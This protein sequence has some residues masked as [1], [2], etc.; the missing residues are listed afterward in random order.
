ML[1]L[2]AVDG[3]RRK[4]MCC[5]ESTSSSFRLESDPALISP[6]VARLQEDLD[7]LGICEGTDRTRVGVALQECLGNALYHGNLEV[8]SDLRQEDERIFYAE[9]DKRRRIAPY[10]DRVIH[11]SADIG[12]DCAT[13]LI[14]DEG[15]GFDTASLDAP[16]DPE[17]LLRIGGRGMILIRSFMDDVRHNASGNAIT[18]I[19]RRRRGRTDD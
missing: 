2:T 13:Y 6:L 7:A 5:L 17:S 8:S 11:V 9:A 1:A 12:R 10:R 19:K 18:L 15:P 4:L 16:F 3:G 14:R